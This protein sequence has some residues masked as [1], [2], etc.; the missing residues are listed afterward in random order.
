MNTNLALQKPTS[1]EYQK[2]KNIQKNKNKPN[3]NNFLYSII[4]IGL[5]VMSS[6]FITHDFYISKNS[7]DLY[8]AVEYNFTN[9]RD[10]NNCLL[11]VQYMSLIN[12]DGKNATVKVSGLSKTRPHHTISLTGN[13]TKDSNKSWQLTDVIEK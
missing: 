9:N 3:K 10:I 7:Q 13:F 12:S 1:Y 2:Q 5:I 6:Y 8:F 11:R 4:T